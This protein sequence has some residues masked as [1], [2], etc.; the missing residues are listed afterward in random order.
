MSLRKA[1]DQMCKVCCYDKLDKGSWRQQVENCGVTSCPLWE[2][3]PLTM[4]TVVKNRESRKAEK[5]SA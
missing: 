2:H 4:A 1:V 5:A 3:R